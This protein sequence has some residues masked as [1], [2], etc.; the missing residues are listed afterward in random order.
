MSFKSEIIRIASLNAKRSFTSR[1]L[2]TSIA[3]LVA[4]PLLLIASN[5]WID[6]TTAYFMLAASWAATILSQR[7]FFLIIVYIL[8]RSPIMNP[9]GSKLLRWAELIVGPEKYE[10]VC[11]PVIADWHEEYFEA[12][13]QGRSRIKMAAIRIRHS[14]AFI[15]AVGILSSLEA[16]GKIAKKFVGQ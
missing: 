9:P 2:M 11:V 14:W 13:G 4:S 8:D 3:M 5:G 1:V 7:S 6:T 12:L 10:Q 16:A 15:K